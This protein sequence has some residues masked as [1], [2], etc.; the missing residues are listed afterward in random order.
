M[1]SNKYKYYSKREGIYAPTNEAQRR[2]NSEIVGSYTDSM[3]RLKNKKTPEK[4]PKAK[5]MDEYHS[6]NKDFGAAFELVN[7]RF[8]NI[9]FSPLICLNWMGIDA[10]K[11]ILEAFLQN[12]RME[13]A[14]KRAK[15]INESIEFEAIS[16]EDVVKFIE[17][18]IK[19]LNNTKG[20]REEDDDAR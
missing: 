13:D 15:E 17:A 10:E 12:S 1:G 18:K 9:V 14:L 3:L 4:G 16:E 20:S 2:K 6:N 11:E 7:K 19:E 5:F 8:E